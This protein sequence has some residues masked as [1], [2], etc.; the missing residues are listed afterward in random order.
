METAPDLEEMQALR[1]RFQD[2]DRLG[3]AWM[4]S[5]LI[6]MEFLRAK[7]DVVQNDVDR[8]LSFHRDFI[9]F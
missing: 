7:P 3:A 4:I 6:E 2:C 5:A 8:A 1:R 9:D